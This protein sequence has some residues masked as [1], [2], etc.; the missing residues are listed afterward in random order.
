MLKAHKFFVGGLLAILLASTATA[1]VNQVPFFSQRD[2]RWAR[3]QLGTCS[4]DTIG[5]AGCAITS[6]SMFVAA[7]GSVVDPAR[8]NTWLTNNR[9]YVDGCSLIWSRAADYDGTGGLT[10]VGTGTLSTP[11]S[12]KSAVDSGRLVVMKSNRFAA[13]G[14]SH[15][16]ALR[17][18]NNAGTVWS[19]FVYWDPW[20]TLP[21]TRRIGD[22][23]WVVSGAATRIYR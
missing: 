23:S 22:S 14:I 18:Y 12:L 10:W 16:V 1:A 2:S 8:M 9:G 17:G 3:Q 4:G 7:R 15:W 6:V 20:D 21:T 13:A 11:A 19:D 5:S